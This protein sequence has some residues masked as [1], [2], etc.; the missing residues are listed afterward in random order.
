[1]S[2]TN[3]YISFDPKIGASKYLNNLHKT[4]PQDASKCS[5]KYTMFRRLC[6]D[7]ERSTMTTLNKC[8][9]IELIKWETLKEIEETLFELP[10]TKSH[11]LNLINAHCNNYLTTQ[12]YFK[13]NKIRGY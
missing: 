7:V 10:K 3:T 8:Q 6:S 1:M 13:S 4:S 2:D 5:R 9:I 11:M 12:K